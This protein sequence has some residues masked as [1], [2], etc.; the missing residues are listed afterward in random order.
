LLTILSKAEKLQ[1]IIELEREL[2]S[3][4]YEIENYTG[5]LKKW[6]N[7]I[8][9]S[10]VTIDVYEVLEI[11]EEEPIP[12]TWGDRIINGFRKSCRNL[13]EMFENLVILMVSA[14]P[15]LALLGIIGVGIWAIVIRPIARKIAR[16]KEAGGEE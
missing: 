1:D 9:Y 10:K 15:Y 8:D 5:T 12:I 13:W 2:S 4:R 7:L 6:D 16:R 11:K 3:V 14:V